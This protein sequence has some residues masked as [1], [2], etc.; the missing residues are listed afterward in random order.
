MNR[1]FE[2]PKCEYQSVIVRYRDYVSRSF[3]DERCEP[4]LACRCNRCDFIWRE[5]TSDEAK[6]KDKSND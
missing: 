1:I 3:H 4:Y 2:C 6:D 5:A